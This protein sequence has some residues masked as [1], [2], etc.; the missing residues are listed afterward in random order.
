MKLA[1]EADVPTVICRCSGRH[2]KD[3][4]AFSIR[5]MLPEAISFIDLPRSHV[6]PAIQAA[7]KSFEERRR[8]GDAGKMFAVAA[9]Y[10]WA[11]AV[12]VAAD[13]AAA[14]GAVVEASLRLTHSAPSF[15]R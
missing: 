10:G 6:A 13:E 9:V 4:P 15:D 11:E 2:S 12:L 7:A 14:V 8:Q 3:V 5:K 1:V